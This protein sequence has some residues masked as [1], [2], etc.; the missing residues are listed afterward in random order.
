MEP[1]RRRRHSITVN[2]GTPID[3]RD[4][5][6][7]EPSGQRRLELIARLHALRE[8]CRAAGRQLHDR[9]TFARIQAAET[10]VT[11]AIRIVEVVSKSGSGN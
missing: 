2:E 7:S 6:R 5:L 11:A 3:L 9:D 4:E 8:A 10:A 1:F